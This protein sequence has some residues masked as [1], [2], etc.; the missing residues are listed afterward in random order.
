MYR[1]Q[2]FYCQA[3]LNWQ[4]LVGLEGIEKYMTDRE[5]WSKAGGGREEK[6]GVRGIDKEERE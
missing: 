3:K 2:L 5:K 4:R 1:V 6:R